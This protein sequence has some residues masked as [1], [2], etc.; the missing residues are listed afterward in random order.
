MFDLSTTHALLGGAV[1]AVVAG[2]T[3]SGHCALMCG[4][5]ACVTGGPGSDGARRKAAQAWH[6]GRIV[7]YV[8]V[9]ALLGAFGRGVS[10][11]LTEAARRYVGWLM[12]VGL[13]LMALEV[14][15]RLP[16]I[17][18]LRNISR[19][20][21]FSGEKFSPAV[22]A[23]LRGAATPFLPC[24]L[25]YGAFVMAIGAGSAPSGALVMG[26]FGLGAIPALALVQAQGRRLADY[27]CSPRARRVAARVVPLLA[28]GLLVWRTLAASGSAPPCH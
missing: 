13:V 17:P 24:G 9:G 4:P 12:V 1:T 11:V 14:G 3:G 20:I 5:L 16:A 25:L 19:L 23:L 6:L 28:A 21:A 27:P 18:G 26:A 7:A 15:K 22:R 8:A 2:A 10:L